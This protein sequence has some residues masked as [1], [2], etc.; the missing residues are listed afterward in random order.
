MLNEYNQQQEKINS[1]FSQEVEIIK[2]KSDDDEELDGTIDAE[3]GG[4]SKKKK[5]DDLTSVDGEK[6]IISKH[7]KYLK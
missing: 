1:S 4:C 5:T 6:N 3:N 7:A 2:R